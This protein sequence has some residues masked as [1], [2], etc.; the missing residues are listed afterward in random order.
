MATIS[1]IIKQNRPNITNSSVRTYTSVINNLA[2]K[3]KIEIKSPNDIK[4]HCDAILEYLKENYPQENRRKT[5]L[6][7][8]VVFLGKE[9]EN[10]CEKMRNLMLKDIE[11]S[12]EQ[13]KQKLFKKTEKED[14]NWMN[15]SDVIKKYEQL[16]KQVKPLLSNETLNKNQYQLVQLYTL[17]S[18]IVLGV[19]RR[20]LDY[21]ELKKPTA[22][23]D[24]EKDNYFD[25]KNKELVYSTYKTSKK[26]GTTKVKLSDKAYKILNKFITYIPEKQEYIFRDTRGNKMTPSKLTNLLNEFF[27]PKK[28]STSMLRHIYL[29]SVFEK[30]PSNIFEINRDMGHS[31]EQA[32]MYK[33]PQNEE[34]SE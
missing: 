30:I 19:P 29:S 34:K 11:V 25:K 9:H 18:L 13:D 27:S 12:Q 14:K 23:I 21:C 8:I 4:K 32:V 26:Y 7:S 3:M 24:K 20:S 10:V 28:I 17:L 31:L 16:E 22:Q 15:W 6:A 5:I 33:R 1:E 2:S